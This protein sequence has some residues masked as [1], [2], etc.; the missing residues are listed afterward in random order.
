MV[1]K[2][3]IGWHGFATFLRGVPFADEDGNMVV[4]ITTTGRPDDPF[5]GGDEVLLEEI[6]A[7]VEH[8]SRRF[9]MPA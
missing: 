9:H 8:G 6:E 7:E 3:Y 5:Q 1:T 4:R 2:K